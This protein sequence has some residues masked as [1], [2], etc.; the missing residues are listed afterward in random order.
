VLPELGWHEEMLQFRKEVCRAIRN[1]QALENSQNQLLEFF[2]TLDYFAGEKLHPD[3]KL[4]E[5]WFALDRRHFQITDFDSNDYNHSRTNYRG[6]ALALHLPGIWN[7]LKDAGADITRQNAKSTIESR[8][9][10]SELFLAR[11]VNV[12]MYK[13]HKGLEKKN[14]R[15]YLL[16]LQELEE[17]GMLDDLIEKAK[18]FQRQ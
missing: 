6:L 9:Q 5:G 3:A 12:Y 4:D 16:N 8:I 2:H 17:N 11:S 1:E 15:C 10:N 14:K 7:V 13:S 18:E